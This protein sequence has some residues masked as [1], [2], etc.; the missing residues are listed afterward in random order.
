MDPVGSNLAA[1]LV[2][3]PSDAARAYRDAEAS[4]GGG[5]FG[6][7]LTRA[8]QGV[9]DG[10]QSA[11]AK[12]MQAIAGGGDITDVVTAVSKAEL[13]LQTTVTIR[14]RVVQAYQDIMKMPI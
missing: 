13:A 10:A 1:P 12:S 14:D 11:E 6:S 2:V 7:V 9:A 4:D 8:V 5:D 3:R